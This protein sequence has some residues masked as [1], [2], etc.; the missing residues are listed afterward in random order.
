MYI[1]QGQGQNLYNN[2]L[3]RNVENSVAD[4][5]FVRLC[6]HKINFRQINFFEN[7]NSQQIKLTVSHVSLY[8]ILRRVGEVRRPITSLY[9]QEIKSPKQIAL[10]H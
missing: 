7:K 10:M 2:L 1:W 5:G 4:E 3:T 6:V 9:P 8:I